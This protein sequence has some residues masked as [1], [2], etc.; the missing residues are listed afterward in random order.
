MVMGLQGFMSSLEL[1]PMWGGVDPDTQLYASGRV[2]DDA[3]DWATGQSLTE[4]PGRPCA[5]ALGDLFE[6]LGYCTGPNS[7]IIRST[8]PHPSMQSSFASVGRL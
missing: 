8:H 3:G 5:P 4:P 7:A 2:L 6:Y 1:L